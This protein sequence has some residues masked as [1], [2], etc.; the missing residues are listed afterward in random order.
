M[1]VAC[2]LIHPSVERLTANARD[3]P[4]GTPQLLGSSAQSRFALGFVLASLARDR[5]TNRAPMAYFDC[6]T[7]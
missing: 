7:D 2:A 1:P 3:F 4:G 5:F 6:T